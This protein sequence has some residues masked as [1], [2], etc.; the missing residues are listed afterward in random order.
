M[1]KRAMRVTTVTAS[2]AIAALALSGCASG[3]SSQP[4]ATAAAGAVDLSGIC[5]ATIKIQ[6]DWYPEAEHGHLYEMLG[7]DYT[8]DSNN[9]SVSGPLEVN[10]KA[11]GVNIQINAGG[12]A[13]GYQTVSTQ[14]YQD[15]SIT[16]GYV[17]TD[18]AIQN[19]GKLPTT[20]VYSE[21]NLSPYMIMWD[22]KVYPKV[23]TL[24]ELGQAL[25]KNNNVVRYFSGASYM[26][27]LTAKGI[28]PK[29]ATD[30]SYDGTSAKWVASQG[31]AAQQGFATAEPYI[32]AHEIPAWDQPVK[33]ALLSTTGWSPYTSAISV[34]TGDVSTLSKCLTKLVPIMQQAQVDY[35][36]SPAATNALI[37]KLDHAYSPT[38]SYT[39]ATANYA[40]TT[41]KAD[42]L[43]ADSDGY[44][45]G[46]TTA[47]VNALLKIATPIFANSGTMKSGLTASDLFTDKFLDKSISLGY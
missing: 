2:L 40:A 45:G 42:K 36:K 7:K 17:G 44:V 16:L 11:T 30:G 39:L 19:S 18:E 24:K 27:Y 21:F 1:H 35:M 12:P 33:Y 29:S 22:P 32:Y 38:W 6:T 14:M 47:R 23:T 15:K 34:R 46:M 13:I 37:I 10:G 4:T 25:V 26:D 8:I 20:A 41:M 43:V 31:K 9:K 5:P 3:S 28:I